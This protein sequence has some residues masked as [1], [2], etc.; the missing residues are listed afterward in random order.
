MRKYTLWLSLLI[1]VMM[2]I[3]GMRALIHPGFY[4]SHDGWHQV[5]R[6]FHFDAAIR[7][8]QFPPRWSGGLLNGFGY[9]LFI[10]S[11]HLPWWIAEPFVLLG[12]TIFDSIKLVFLISYIIS[13]IV[14]FLFIRDLWG[15]KAGLTAA[16]IYLL[17]PYRLATILV[18]ANIGEAVSFMCFPLI[19]W[20]LYRLS[21]KADWISIFI[22]ALGIAGSLLSHVMV[23]GLFFLLG[24]S[25]F[26]YLLFQHPNKKIF[27]L[28]ALLMGLLGVG[29]ASYYVLP[30]FFY[31]PITVFAELYHSL[32]KNHFTPISK[33]IYSP[34][35]YAAIGQPGEMS[36]QIGIIV[37]FI[38]S[39]C[40]M[41]VIF[42]LANKKRLQ[43]SKH[44][45][46]G[47]ILITNFIFAVFMMTAASSS[48]WKLIEPLAL[49]DFPWRFLA[50]TTFV[51]S[52][53]VGWLMYSLK[54]TKL[55]L[56]VAIVLFLVTV[57]TTRNYM[58]VNQYTD[59][60][61]SLYV[62]S[63]LTTNTDDEYL[64]KWVSRQK[65]KEEKP[66]IQMDDAKVQLNKQTSNAIWFSYETTKSTTAYIHH[67]YFPQWKAF[68]KGTATHDNDQVM[69]PTRAGE[70]G[71][72]LDLP[73]D[74]RSV[75]LLYQ[76]PLIM[77]IGNLITVIYWIILIGIF[78]KLSKKKI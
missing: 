24:L 72:E 63:E 73:S 42:L 77:T 70:G 16:L 20:G 57:Y 30:A 50:L 28:L 39:L 29:L 47:I 25:Y 51:G 49:I 14:M 6:L 32:Y 76:P 21:K 45:L 55:Q 60:P 65:V 74:K 44:I 54:N 67:M 11:Y 59:I 12:V 58:R 48:V 26:L 66:R 18:R 62:A 7:D 13:G 10:F 38:V 40:S 2:A 46:L 34:W 52:T 43:K 4:T 27:F 56:V 8:G 5:A 3:W 71:M 31:K 53:L 36:R 1:I 15:K 64:P 68:I 9:P 78:I 22:G 37:W 19:F 33:L 23:I 61:L 17:V 35:G 41:V 69:V 75:I